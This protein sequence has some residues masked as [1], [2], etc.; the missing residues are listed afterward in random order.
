[1]ILTPKIVF[2]NN[3]FSSQIFI[4]VFSIN[5]NNLNHKKTVN[6]YLCWYKCRQKYSNGRDCHHIWTWLYEGAIDIKIAAVFVGDDAG[7]IWN[8]RVVLIKETG[9]IISSLYISGYNKSRAL[10]TLSPT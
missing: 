3:L 10:V 9:Q 1:M 8:R 2:Q 6:Q 4:Y 5:E 7:E